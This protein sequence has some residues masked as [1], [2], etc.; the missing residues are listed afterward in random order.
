MA[1]ETETTLKDTLEFIED[2]DT[3]IYDIEAILTNEVD[4]KLLKDEHVFTEEQMLILRAII[5]KMLDIIFKWHDKD[6]EESH[7]NIRNNLR[8]LREEFVNHRH[9]TTQTYSGKPE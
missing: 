3:C 9:D 4:K 7:L 1:K 8:E 6:D 5:N 2:K